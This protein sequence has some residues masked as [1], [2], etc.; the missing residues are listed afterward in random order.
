ML[1]DVI[2]NLCS[3]E[4]VIYKVYLHRVVASWLVTTDPDTYDAFRI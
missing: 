2:I 4:A 1:A 3:I